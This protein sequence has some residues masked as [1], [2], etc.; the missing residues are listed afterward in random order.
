MV[1]NWASDTHILHTS[2][3]ICNLH[4]KQ[5]W[6]KTN[7]NFLRKWSKTV[8]LAY[9][10]AQ[11]WT[12]KAHILHTFKCS[13]NQHVTQYW[14]ETRGNFLRKLPKTRILGPIFGPQN[15]AF[16]AHIVYISKSSSNDHITLRHQI[17]TFSKLLAVCAGNSPFTGEFPTQRPVTQSFDVFFDLRPNKRLSNQSSGSWFEMPSHSL[18]CHCNEARLMWSQRKLF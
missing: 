1:Q 4:V 12:F 5:Y 17:E 13:W 18:W 10:G 11:N 9:F 2:K 7:E 15:W 6:C 16:E 3:S 14:C 8:I